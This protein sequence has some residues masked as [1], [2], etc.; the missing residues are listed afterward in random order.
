MKIDRD[1][2][3]AGGVACAAFIAS[4]QHI[5]SVTVE[6]GNPGV[7]AALHPLAI[8]G[9]IYI[10]IR[11]VQRGQRRSGGFALVYG[12]GYSLAFNA[13]SYGG[14][15]MSWVAMAACLPIALV[16]AVLIVHG[17]KHAEP[18]LAPAVEVREVL[19][20]IV[21][22]GMRT[23]RLVPTPP[24]RVASTSTRALSNRPTSG[25][26]A[27]SWD[28]DKVVDM[29]LKGEDVSGLVSDKVAQRV[30]RVLR[31]AS[32]DKMVAEISKGDLTLTFVQRVMDARTKAMQK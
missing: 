32:E 26:P 10:G 4:A 19:V 6:A 18:E 27:L 22:E 29:L 5:W 24:V 13:A 30:R 15:R 11:S 14:F 17:R 12:A 8:D 28:V 23:L 9:L 20:P 31:A 25:G 21:P 7:I 2:L 16:A 3:V 1:A